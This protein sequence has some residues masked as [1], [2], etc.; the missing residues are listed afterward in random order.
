MS[1]DMLAPRLLAW[2]MT[3]AGLGLGLIAAAFV[4]EDTPV[5]AY[6]GVGLLVVGAGLAVASRMARS[7]Q[8]E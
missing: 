1:I 2:G 3:A 8:G 4:G 6:W 7:K 5:L